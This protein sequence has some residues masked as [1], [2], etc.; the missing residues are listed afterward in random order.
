[1][2]EKV[3]DDWKLVLYLV[4]LEFDGI[5]DIAKTNRAVWIRCESDLANSNQ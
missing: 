1:M 5:L 4:A 2:T 3:A